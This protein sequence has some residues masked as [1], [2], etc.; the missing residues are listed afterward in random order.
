MECASGPWISGHDPRRWA[1][2][3]SSAAYATPGLL[4]G[5]RT[6]VPTRLTVIER[7][8]PRPSLT[9]K[10]YLGIHPRTPLFWLLCTVHHDPSK[11]VTQKER[12]KDGLSPFWG[13]FMLQRPS[14]PSIEVKHDVSFVTPNQSLLV[15]PRPFY[16]AS[17]PPV[18][19]GC[20]LEI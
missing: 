3:H 8:D 10:G 11:D 15:T 17:S 1:L 9:S 12:Q 6:T 20:R 19:L 7:P 18:N 13:I 5:S 4:G 2:S 16:M 14:F